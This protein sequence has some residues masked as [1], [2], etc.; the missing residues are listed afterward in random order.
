MPSFVS[1]SPPYRK[2]VN[3]TP[4]STSALAIG[5]M[6]CFIVCSTMSGVMR[7]TGEY[8]PIPPVLGPSSLS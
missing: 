4:S 6:T 2:P 7:L 3:G 8:E 5:S 1:M